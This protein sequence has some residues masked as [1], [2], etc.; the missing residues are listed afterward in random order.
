MSSQ[1]KNTTVLAAAAAAVEKS[2]RKYSTSTAGSPWKGA[3]GESGSHV[4]SS[5]SSPTSG[6]KSGG[7]R[8]TWGWLIIIILVFGVFLF[9]M[10]AHM[11]APSS[12]RA[13]DTAS[14]STSSIMTSFFPLPSSKS[15]TSSNQVG[16]RLRQSGG[17]ILAQKAAERVRQCTWEEGMPVM[18]QLKTKLGV[19]YESGHW[20]HMAENLMVQHSIL[21]AQQRLTNASE[22]Y[23]HLDEDGCTG[24]CVGGLNGMTKFMITIGTVVPPPPAPPSPAVLAAAFESMTNRRG[25][26]RA[27]RIRAE[28]ES[29]NETAQTPQPPPSLVKMIHFFNV[30]SSASSSASASTS[31]SSK[32]TPPPLSTLQAGDTVALK[33]IPPAS[34]AAHAGVK[35]LSQSLTGNIATESRF[36]SNPRDIASIPSASA[37]VKMNG[38]STVCVKSMGRIGGNWP[39]PQRGHWFP[40]DGDVA[41]F[42]DKIRGL[43]PMDQTKLDTFAKKAPFKLMIYQR[44]LSRKL[45]QESSALELLRSRLVPSVWEIQV[46]MHEKD[47]SPC[48]LA[49]LLNNVDVLITAHGFQS[50]LLLFLPRPSILFEVFPYRYYKRGYGPLSGEYGVIHGGFMSPPLTWHHKMLLSM[51]TTEWCMSNKQCR[52][53]ARSADVIFTPQ[54]LEV[55]VNMLHT[56][57]HQIGHSVPSLHALNSTFSA[58]PG[59]GSAGVDGVGV[60]LGL[61]SSHNVTS[62]S[63]VGAGSFHP[64]PN[65]N[66]DFLYTPL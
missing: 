43:C 42:R 13:S 39:T 19:N 45:A 59:T 5:G 37:G 38:D 50:M 36:I 6:S 57:A 48:E 26:R 3:L 16:S 12:T 44:D 22:V 40:N 34:G 4:P 8:L 61:G 10:Y 20:F 32:A 35:I 47:R 64:S 62:G 11:L 14:T 65:L 33:N 15:S 21:R 24:G 53:Y 49:H 66:R 18:Y 60:G 1:R 28:L 51:V 63:G 2:D 30:D 54:A 58:S 7:S 52:G 46:I 27:K 56:H 55:L 23:Y 17:G 29:N 25:R 9:L 41:T 31:Q